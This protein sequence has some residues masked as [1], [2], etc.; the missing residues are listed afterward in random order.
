MRHFLAAAALTLA[1]ALPA[2]AEETAEVS[3]LKTS[4]REAASAYEDVRDYRAQFVKQELSKNELG[5]RETIF[6]KFEKPF[7]I[8][9]RWADTHKKGL[10]VL[11]ER[12]RHGGKLAIHQPGLLLGLAP[13]V[14]L[15]QNSPWVKEGSESYDIEDAG[16][17]SFLEDFEEMVLKGV[18]DG[19]I[20][21][22]TSETPEGK[23]FDVSFPGSIDGDDYFASRVTVLFDA[24]TKLPVRMSLYDWEGRVTGNYEYNELALNVGAA[25]PEFKKIAHGRLY[26]LYVPPPPRTVQKTN[27][28]RSA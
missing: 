4:L 28:A 16:I 26:K 3:A 9:M 22:K 12:G 25:D 8:F 10:Q 6:L 2:A 27:F 23:K 5:P 11:Y 13:V 17:G 21:A 18:S 14:F 15:D 7:K 19:K 1:F 20:E 24:Q